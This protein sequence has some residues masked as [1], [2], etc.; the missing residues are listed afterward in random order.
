MKASDTTSG[1][2]PVIARL[3]E[4]INQISEDQFVLILKELLKEQFSAQMFKLVIDLSDEQQAALLKH[5]HKKVDAH[6][7]KERRGHSRKSC[8]IPLTYVVQGRQFD[9]YILDI[10]NHGVFIETSN[11]FFSGQEIIM[12]FSAPRFQKPLTITGEIAW[13]SQN[14]IGVKFNDLTTHQRKAI[15]EFSE[16]K[17]E[18][19]Q[20]RS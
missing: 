6:H 2:Y 3:F 5:L 20:I 17:A 11:A 13:S 15:T 9:G 19:Y 10:S 18:V 4:L 12:T 8:L 14:G 1:K 16:N 7:S